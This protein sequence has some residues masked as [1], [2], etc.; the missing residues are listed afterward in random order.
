MRI[1]KQERRRD[2]RGYD[3]PLLVMLTVKQK[4]WVAK[5]AFAQRISKAAV[6]RELINRTA[7]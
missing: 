5:E 4:D 3:N 7:P 2:Y 6:I 1:I